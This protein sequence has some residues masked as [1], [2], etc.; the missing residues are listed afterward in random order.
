MLHI[1]F[2]DPVVG[3]VADIGGHREAQNNNGAEIKQFVLS[4]ASIFINDLLSIIF[5]QIE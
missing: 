5:V 2:K 4:K 3:V 1:L